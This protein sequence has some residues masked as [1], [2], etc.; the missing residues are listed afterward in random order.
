MFIRICSKNLQFLRGIFGGPGAKPPQKDRIHFLAGG[1]TLHARRCTK[2][3]LNCLRS[4]EVAPL[5]FTSHTHLNCSS[6]TLVAHKSN[7][8]KC[9]IHTPTSVNQFSL[10]TLSYLR[11]VTS[12]AD[13]ATVRQDGYLVSSVSENSNVLSIYGYTLD[14]ITPHISQLRQR[15]PLNPS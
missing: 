4:P 2:G 5:S 15:R 1:T 14:T 13:G 12:I 11:Y 6:R 8:I 3:F 7:S 9:R 10:F